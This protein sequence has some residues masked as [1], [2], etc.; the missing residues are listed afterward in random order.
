MAHTK[1]SI[2]KVDENKIIKKARFPDED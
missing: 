1:I 2:T